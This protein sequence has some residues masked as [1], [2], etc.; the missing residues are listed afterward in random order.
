M[1]AHHRWTF[2]TATSFPTAQPQD[3]G[4]LG[5]EA[6]SSE[7]K[8]RF[9][10]NVRLTLG[11]SQ[12]LEARFSSRHVFPS[13]MIAEATMA[14]QQR[15]EDITIRQNLTTSEWKDGHPPADQ[16]AGRA[17]AGGGLPSLGRRGHH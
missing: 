4:G 1:A 3:P 6:S 17:H 12:V 8:G 11:D 9:M 15:P 13:E 16:R 7:P 14:L 10:D 2:L 5:V